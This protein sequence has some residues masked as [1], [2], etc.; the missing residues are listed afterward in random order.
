LVDRWEYNRE[1][2]V[3]LRVLLERGKEHAQI[4]AKEGVCAPVQ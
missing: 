4:V 2:R 3:A 1:A